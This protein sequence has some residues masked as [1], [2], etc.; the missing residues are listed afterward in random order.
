M[1]KYFQP[2]SL[3]WWGGLVPL[4]AGLILAAA[5]AIPALH[6]LALFINAA[7]GNMP[8]PVLINAGLVAIGLRGAIAR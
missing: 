2:R 4:V 5:D 6:G 8:A 3:T 7:S 1:T